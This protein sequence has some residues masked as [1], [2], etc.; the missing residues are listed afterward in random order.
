M[1]RHTEDA[2]DL[3]HGKLLRF[4]ELAVL[5]RKRDWFIGHALFQHCHTMGIGCTAISRF[6]AITDTVRVFHNAGM[7]QHTTGLCAVLEERGTVFI[8][9]NGSTEAV[10][11]HGDWRETDQTIKPKPRHMKD[12]VPAKVEVFI[13][14]SRNFIRVCVVDIVELAT[15]ISVHFDILRQKRI[16]TQHRVLAIPDDLCVSVAPEK[17]VGH[18]RFPEDKGCHLRVGLAIQNLIQRMIPRL[19]LVAV[20]VCHPVQM[21]RQCRNGLCQQTDTG[22]HSRDLHG[23]FLI[24]LLPGIGAAKHKGLPGIADVIRDLRQAFFWLFC[25]GRIPWVLKPHPFPE[26]H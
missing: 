23:C 4:E 5:W 21:Q 17:Q 10:L 2:A 22:I 16:Q 13:L 14:L 6:P 8:Y 15:L 26:S 12:L 9:R 7:L 19:F 3:R 11:H 20:I 18:Q 1:R 25:F 24:H